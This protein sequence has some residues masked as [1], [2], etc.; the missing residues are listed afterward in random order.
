MEEKVGE[1]EERPV[2]QRHNLVRSGLERGDVAVGT[3]HRRN[4]TPP[5][6]TSTEIAP[7]GGGARSVM[8]FVKFSTPVP[9]SLRLF[10]GLNSKASQF[11]PGQFSFGNCG[12]VM[13][14]SFR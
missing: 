14:I 4:S 11:P 2:G 13:P 12:L 3:A 6:A 9:S 5:T 7:R 1:W 8:K 10:A